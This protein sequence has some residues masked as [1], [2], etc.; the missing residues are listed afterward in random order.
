MCAQEHGNLYLLYGCRAWTRNAAAAFQRN[1][2]CDGNLLPHARPFSY[3]SP[4]QGS[5]PASCCLLGWAGRGM[6]LWDEAILQ[7]KNILQE[8]WPELLVLAVGT[9]CLGHWRHAGGKKGRQSWVD[10]SVLLQLSQLYYICE[11]NHAFILHVSSDLS[12]WGICI[13][14]GAAALLAVVLLLFAMQIV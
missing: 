10:S 4:V 12:M 2:V 14:Q 13:A 6:W 11:I 1:V 7:N 3:S 5:L 8:F 9:W